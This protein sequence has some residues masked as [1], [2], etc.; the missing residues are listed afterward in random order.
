MS[1]N[2][3]DYLIDLADEPVLFE[4]YKSQPDKTLMDARISKEEKAALRSADPEQIKTLLKTTLIEG[5]K[6]PERVNTLIGTL[7]KVA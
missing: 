3:L 7:P 4:Q 2:F 6:I 1:E 5:Q